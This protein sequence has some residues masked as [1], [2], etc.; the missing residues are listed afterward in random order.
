MSCGLAL[1]KDV[2]DDIPSLRSQNDELPLLDLQ[3]H[4]G[5][6]MKVRAKS[7]P[8]RSSEAYRRLE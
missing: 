7:R 1:G 8:G 2:L 4:C 6:S 5:T 3:C